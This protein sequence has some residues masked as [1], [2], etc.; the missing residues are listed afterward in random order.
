LSFWPQ[1]RFIEVMKFKGGGGPT[2]TLLTV[3]TFL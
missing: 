2:Q 1:I 3:N